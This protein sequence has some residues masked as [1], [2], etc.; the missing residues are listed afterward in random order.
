MGFATSVEGVV[1]FVEGRWKAARERTQKA[2]TMLREGCLGVAWEIDNTN[3]YSLAS[4]FYLGNLKELADGLPAVLKEAED[5][6]DLYAATNIRTRLS[7]LVRL[8]QDRP[9]EAREELERAIGSWSSGDFYLQHWYE[10]LGQTEARLYAGEAADAWEL[11][12]SRWPLLDASLLLHVQSVRINSLHLRARSAIALAA[13]EPGGGGHAR[14]LRGSIRDARRIEREKAP[15]GDALARLLRAGIASAAGDRP[16]AA[17]LLESAEKAFES[18]DMA[19]HAAVARRR[20]GELAGGDDGRALVEAADAWMAG[21]RIQNP[22][23][24]AAMLAPGAF[25]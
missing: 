5:R 21:Q 11:L 23:R 13:L 22:A 12:A 20:R 10:L 1:A 16:Q 9:L 3:Y 18:A 24:M 14:L 25:A 8:A 2:G 19:L 15:W 4:L 7:Y 17:L 6:G